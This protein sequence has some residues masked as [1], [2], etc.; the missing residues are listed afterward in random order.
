MF[1]YLI[2][3]S[4][5]PTNLNLKIQIDIL[6]PTQITP[7]YPSP[8]GPSPLPLYILQLALLPLYCD[9][10]EFDS[11]RRLSTGS[12]KLYVDITDVELPNCADIVVEV[13]LSACI[14]IVL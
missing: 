2:C 3:K 5:S 6:H 11:V 1:G 7:D 4:N 8:P 14:R 9:L 10:L 13:T 12:E